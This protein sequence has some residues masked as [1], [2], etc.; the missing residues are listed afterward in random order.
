MHKMSSDEE[1]V[2]NDDRIE[3][4]EEDEEFSPLEQRKIMQRVDI[5]LVAATGLAYSI[6]LMDRG[7][8]SLAAIS[9]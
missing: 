4:V 5:R 8:I 7:N 3:N 2:I 6:S 1:K 9:G